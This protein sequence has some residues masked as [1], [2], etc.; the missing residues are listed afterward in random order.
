MGGDGGQVRKRQRR[1]AEG[2][3]GVVRLGFEAMFVPAGRS[4]GSIG[5]ETVED[6]SAFQQ[7]Y[8]FS[9]GFDF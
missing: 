9:V 8:T 5:G 1:L 7:Q 6:N 2:A 3:P 4:D